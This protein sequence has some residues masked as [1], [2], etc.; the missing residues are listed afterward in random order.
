MGFGLYDVDSQL[1]REGNQLNLKLEKLTTNTLKISWDIPK[2]K[3]VYDGLIVT[4]STSPINQSNYPT[5]GVRYE[6][7]TDLSSPIHK[8]GKAIVV[9]AFYQDQTTDHIIVSNANS[10][11]L[12]YASAHIC[13]SVLNYHDM[14]VRSY[15]EEI[16][17]DAFA[18]SLE[19]NYDPP[20]NP[21]IGEV[22]YDI[23]HNKTL[24]WHG[25]AWVSAG[26]GTTLTGN[27][28]PDYASTGQFFYHT[29]YKELYVWSDSW[30]LA[31]KGSEKKPSYLKTGIGTDRSY[32]ERSGLISVLKTM[33][34]W[35]TQ[36]LE[37]KDNH[38]NVSIDNALQE[39]R[40]RCDSAYRSAFIMMRIKPN[41]QTYYLNN[42]EDETDKI[43]QIIRIHRVRNLGL[44]AGGADG[45]IWA[46]IFA[47]HFYNMGQV[48]F[49]TIHL[50]A[51]YA[52]T[53]SQLFA[54]E[55][56]FNWRETTR[57]LKLY[58]KMYAEETVLL[59]CALDKTEQ[60][61]LL[62]RFTN[63]WIQ[64]WALS[65]LKL[66]LGHIRTK[67]GSIPGPNG[68]ITMNGDTLFQ[69][70]KEEQTELL[71]QLQEFEVGNLGEFGST[72]LIIG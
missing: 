52:E 40:M 28:F 5:N 25:G 11:D 10:E 29:G 62:D 32:D 61:L 44:Y 55:I 72:G 50:T 18:P 47:N 27:T 19:K 23:K 1:L 35:P 12:Y 51:S 31:T 69:Q 58:K 53:F 41:Q 65:E 60:E 63:Q 8:I 46:Q 43:A 15:A 34:G 17:V 45:G 71:R 36:C 59:E 16:S 42:P 20:E 24:M 67:F 64:S 70:G 7:S 54:A 37:L 33:L 68:G 39:L 9:G 14:G 56:G 13:N 66:I 49:V 57:E 26:N 4:L 22:Y 6:Y 21:E 2:N 30:V 48:D 38:F 3:E